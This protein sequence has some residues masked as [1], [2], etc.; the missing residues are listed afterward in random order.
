I[1][2]S[3]LERCPFWLVKLRS[4]EH[5]WPSSQIPGND[6]H[7]EQPG[8]SDDSARLQCCDKA[9]FLSFYPTNVAYAM[10]RLVSEEV[11]L[12]FADDII[13]DPACQTKEVVNARLQPSRNREKQA[14]QQHECHLFLG[15]VPT[16]SRF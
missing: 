13:T 3:A 11:F 6:E 2:R 14:T 10:L 12:T 7:H 4:D 8:V 1:V 5:R 15:H 16:V 9:T